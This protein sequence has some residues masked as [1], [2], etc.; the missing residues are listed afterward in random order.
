M[1]V[2]IDEVKIKQQI[3]DFM[4][5]VSI[6]IT[7]DA[8]ERIGD[9]REYLRPET[10]VF[11]GLLP[12]GDYRDV[13][14]TAIRLHEN[15][16]RVV[17]HFT[18][19]NIPVAFAFEDY[20]N[21]VCEKAAVEEVLVL[22]GDVSVPV[23]DY[24]SSMQLLETG[25]FEKYGIKRIGV[26]GH[27]EGTPD[28]SKTELSHAL[29]KK[30]AFARQSDADFYILTQ[31]CFDAAAIIAWEEQINAAGNQ[32]PIC[33]GIAGPMALG[34]LIKIA[35]K[36]KVGDSL[37]MMSRLAGGLIES[38]SVRTSDRVVTG[39]ARHKAATTQ[40]KIQ[41]AHIFTFG[42]LSKASKWINAAMDGEIKMHQQGRA[43]SL[44][45]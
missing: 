28:I 26:A 1:L 33:A 45:N 15:G 30:N 37:R 3:V 11:I 25:L 5:G 7:P 44:E 16:F 32:L 9:F 22:A 27:P 36:C 24:H 34:P 2:E 8:A 6:S 40:S 14:K 35:A 18:A 17:P 39:L 4:Q 41:G 12:G 23:G 19:R 31:F 13:V 42:N 38:K 29:M 43:F 21:S 10:T 20:L